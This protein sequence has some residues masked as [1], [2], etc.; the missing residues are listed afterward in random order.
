MCLGLI[1]RC[2]FDNFKENEYKIGI[3]KIAALCGVSAKHFYKAYSIASVFFLSPSGISDKT[4]SE[5]LAFTYF[6]SLYLDVMMNTRYAK[7]Y[8]NEMENDHSMITLVIAY[9]RKALRLLELGLKNQS[10]ETLLNQNIK[11][12]NELIKVQDELRQNLAKNVMRNN[13]IYKQKG[14]D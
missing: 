9:E 3:N 11:Q 5:M 8:G 13:E 10:V 7:Y 1:Y 12:K 4:K 6:S 2:L 14:T